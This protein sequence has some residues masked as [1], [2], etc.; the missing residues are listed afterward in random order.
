VVYLQKAKWRGLY[1][2]K[3]TIELDFSDH[4]ILVGPN[5]AGKSNVLRILN[6]LV[7]SF[8]YHERLGYSKIY[9]SE[10]NPFLEVDLQFS[11]TETQKIIDFFCF[12]LDSNNNNSEFR[13]LDNCDILL[14]LFD[15]VIIK[16]DWVRLVEGDESNGYVK[17]EFPKTG[18]KFFGSIYGDFSVS[19][20]YHDKNSAKKYSHVKFFEILKEIKDVESAKKIVNEFFGQDFD[21]ISA[22]KIS[23]GESRE[24]LDKG[25]IILT[26]LFSFLGLSL[27]SSKDAYFA[28]LLGVI[29][30]NG[31]QISSGSKGL[32]TKSIIDTAEKLAT[33]NREMVTTKEGDQ[34]SFNTVLERQ[35]FDKMLEFN[36]NLESDGSNLIL[37]LFSLKNSAKQKDRN[38]FNKIQ[39]E[40]KKLF[41]SDKLSFD[42]ILQYELSG[43]HRVWERTEAS[44]AKIPV[45]MIQDENMQRQF[46]VDQV[47][48]GLL[49]TIYLLT[50]AHGIENSIILLDEPAVNLHPTLMKSIVNSL[51]NST[52]NN[53]FIII[54]HSPELTSYEIFDNKASL[55]YVRKKKNHSIIKILSGETKQ[56]FEEQRHRL[57]HQID[58][59]IFFGKSVLLT[60]GDSDKNLL[61]GIANSF[62]S[63]DTDVNITQN[64]VIIT[65]VGSKFN[66]KKYLNL[67][68]NFDIPYLV[69][70]DSDA[71]D[72]FENSG[73]LSQKN[74]T[75]EDSIVIIED[76]D[77]EKLMRDIDLE[78][79]SKA[80]K[81]NG[82]SKPAVAYA[83]AEEISK[84]YPNKL[85]SIKKLLI[86]SI[87]L[88]RG[89]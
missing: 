88:A 84:R 17:M 57:K 24:F 14:E 2:F 67:V 58:A 34:I 52:L 76:G 32:T 8:Y 43:R 30:K 39:E 31:F 53:Q 71:K 1:S 48:A 22:P 56:W 37:F 86:R 46:A 15:N 49:E 23:I 16:L 44:R 10:H 47:G 33:S 27:S 38:K 18:F 68:K 4:S 40:F 20:L 60:E 77:L 70:G 36:E 59:R 45:I 35:A 29:F 55:I 80:E 73:T 63:T 51:Q 83:F 64:D 42:I 6:I 19:N 25:R 66:F 21:H 62:E 78:L 41:E 50:L 75:F 85:D 61:E 5:N 12:P 26:D 82:R 79:Y 9:L 54:T 7:D 65:N 69:L 81:E 28:E 11:R 13:E 3:D 87:E 72:L 74:I 89:K